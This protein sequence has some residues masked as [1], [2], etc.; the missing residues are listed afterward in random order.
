MTLESYLERFKNIKGYKAAVI[1]NVGG[2]ILTQDSIDPNIDLGL[3]SAT[4]NDLF[5][6]AHQ[7]SDKIGFDP[8]LEAAISTNKGMIVMRCS[9]GKGKDHYH[10]IAIFSLE[11]D[12]ILCQAELD[13][14]FPG[15]L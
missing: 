11:T 7:A 10:L 14:C 9:G 1:M 5:R 6:K 8:C 15:H 13:E 3:L 12:Q 4:F 2:E